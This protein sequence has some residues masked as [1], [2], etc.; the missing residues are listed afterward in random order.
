MGISNFPVALQPA[1]QQNFL[2][3]EFEQALRAKLG[4]RR[5]ADSERFPN[6]VGETITKTRAG[7]K[8][9]VETP[10]DPTTNTGFDNGLTP[11]Q[12]W[13]IEQFTLSIGM[14]GTSNDL[15]T[16]TT[17]VGIASQFLQNA[18]ANG[19]QA[20][21][22]L[23]SIARNALFNSYLGGNT[24]VTATLGAAGTTISVDD[25]RGFQYVPNATNNLMVP[26][27]ATNPMTVVVG[28]NTYS[29]ESVAADAANV[30]TAWKGISG[31]LTFSGNVTVADGTAGEP[32]IA[33]IAPTILRPN[34]R[35]TTAQLV[36]GD[37][38][39][40]DMIL[41]AKAQMSNNAVPDIDG[42]YNIYMDPTS[43]RSIFKD[44]QFQLLYRGATGENP[45]YRNGQITDFLGMRFIETNMS[46]QQSAPGASGLTVH[47]PV[48]CGQGTLIE[49]NFDNMV[50]HETTDNAII[51]VVDD[52]VQVTREPLDRWQ[53][54][55]AQSWYWI[56]G[57]C[58]PTDV[59][60]NP[61]TVP[62]ASNSALKRSIVLE[63]V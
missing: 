11:D 54:I 25:I 8:A 27:S 38:L 1:I 9:A 42:A 49:G 6:G 43:M 29:L 59:T 13:G 39:T 35:Q 60:T 53:Q 18:K 37:T 61:T 16:V 4:F 57:F 36:S 3:R 40:M 51:H 32:V 2:E 47:R 50:G 24:R 19:E 26:V 48:I 62:T 63:H 30:S 31:K 14:Y 55:I 21:R 5:I 34:G 23:D 17:R 12:G 7:L 33:S 44:S 22:S 41:D 45:V 15:N 56:G 52:V 58:A 20:S 46:P 28:S 10:I